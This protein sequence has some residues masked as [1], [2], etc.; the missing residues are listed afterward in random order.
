M[1]YVVVIVVVVIVIVDVVGLVIITSPGSTPPAETLN[2]RS[3]IRTRVHGGLTVFIS[4]FTPFV[5]LNRRLRRRMY[6]RRC[7]FTDSV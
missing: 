1:M 7:S 4:I 2:A 5:Q 6:R 3:L